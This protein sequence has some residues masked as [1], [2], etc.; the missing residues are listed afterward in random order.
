MHNVVRKMVIYYQVCLCY[1]Q[2]KHG[3][4][5]VAVVENIENDIHEN[6]GADSTLCT[7]AQP[8]HLIVDFEKAVINCFTP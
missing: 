7:D 4:T 6:V 2:I 5:K 8:T 3:Q 1:L